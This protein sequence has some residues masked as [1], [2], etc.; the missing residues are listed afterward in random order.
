MLTAQDFDGYALYNS[1]NSNTTYLING[2]A[3]ITHTWSLDRPC[4]YA[5]LLMPN[6]NIMR[7]AVR[8]GNQI[9]GP[10][11]GGLVQEIDPQGNVVWEFEYSSADYVSHHDMTLMPDGNVLLT[12]WEVKEEDEL[13]AMGYTGNQD[14]R[15]PTHFIEVSQINDT[16]QGEIVWEWHIFDH[17]VQ[18]V[19]PDLP[20][21]GIISE[22]PEL[23]DI[24]VETSGGGGGG[25]GPG[26]NSG[27]WFHVN[28]VDYNAER[29][30]ITFS[31]RY[32]SEIFIIDHSTTTEEA[33]GH[34][35]GNSGKG[36]DFLY[37][38]GN[39]E[40]YGMPGEQMIGGPVHD[41]RFIPDD[42]R[43]RGGY[44]QF[45]NNRAQPN[46][47]TV[48]ALELPLAADGYNY[49]RAEGQAW[50]PAEP[51]Y[52]HVCLDY[53][54]GQSASNSMP[55]GNL[56]VNLSMQY[57]YEINPDG[58][59][60]WQYNNDSPKA[61]RY[62]CDYAGTEALNA[63]GVSDDAC[64]FLDNTDDIS[65]ERIRIAPN[66]SAGT[67]G[68]N[69]IEASYDLRGVTVTDVVGNTV[70]IYGPVNSVDLST[71]PA[72]IYFLNLHFAEAGTVTKK[73]SVVR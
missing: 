25:G 69:G 39:P 4:N 26:G 70:A 10:A 65:V 38:W 36:G 9:N 8:Q 52:R 19:D 1:Q 42:G 50:G 55:D 60:I 17:L 32:L 18:D 61:F 34:T 14:E 33:A 2:E 23:M 54:N 71:A 59:V 63:A 30:Q 51:T 56:F 13:T 58:D 66:P 31:S 37:R 15:W 68:I 72:G 49:D 3:D 6:G 24:N 45:F 64:S 40:N 43:P 28:G 7:G 53:A 16:N 46:T 21:Y 48:D 22:H 29:D 12:A 57:M 11:V 5:V 20:G 73:V 62:V 47:S 35:G 41:A 27:D 44:L 67:F